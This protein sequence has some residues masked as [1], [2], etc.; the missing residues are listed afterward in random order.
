MRMYSILCYLYCHSAACAY[1]LESHAC[2]LQVSLTFAWGLN[3]MISTDF[4]TL[5]IC[6]YT[7]IWT[8]TGA[9]TRVLPHSFP[10][11]DAQRRSSLV[12]LLVTCNYVAMMSL[13]FCIG[14]KLRNAERLESTGKC[15]AV[16][17][18]NMLI[19]EQWLKGKCFSMHPPLMLTS[20]KLRLKGRLTDWLT[21]WVIDRLTQP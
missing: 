12:P 14:W 11:K 13:I 9:H 19:C 7:S 15:L 10:H 6:W 2:R 5:N 16:W 1:S 18:T 20:I 8:W 3:P 4:H 17:N 21:D